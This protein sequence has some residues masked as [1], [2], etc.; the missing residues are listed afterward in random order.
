M[1]LWLLALKLDQSGPL[2]NKYALTVLNPDLKDFGLSKTSIAEH[3]FPTIGALT[4]FVVANCRP[5]EVRIT[6]LQGQLSDGR[7]YAMEISSES[8]LRMGFKV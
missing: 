4:K 5:E 6:E 3:S 2:G 1:T 8:S 7:L